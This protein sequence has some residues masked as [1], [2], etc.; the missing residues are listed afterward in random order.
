A[1][2]LNLI[3]RNLLNNAI[4]FSPS[5]SEI[6]LKAEQINNYCKLSVQDSGTGIP[7]EKRKDLFSFRAASSYGTHQEKGVGL[8]LVLCKEFAEIQNGSIWFETETGKGTCFF[9]QLPL[10]HNAEIQ[11]NKRRAPQA[12]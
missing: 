3:V 11:M 9:V 1:N 4:K 7:E 12:P 8:G 10:G 6:I 5:G 2:M